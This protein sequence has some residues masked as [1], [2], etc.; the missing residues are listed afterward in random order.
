MQL[1]MLVAGCVLLGQAP[2]DAPLPFAV[3]QQ[4]AIA[5]TKP[6]AA[7]QVV[8][9]SNPAARSTDDDVQTDRAEL[10]EIGTDGPPAETPLPFVPPAQSGPTPPEMVAEALSPPS[11]SQLAGQPLT[12]LTALSSTT[13]HRHQLEVTHAYW[14]LAEA[15]AV[16]HFSLD[17]DR[18]LR[19][20]EAGVEQAPC[21]RTARASSL[22][23]V[24][25]A[26]V[27]AVA[28][29]HELAA[30]V[31]LSP[32]ASLPLPADRPHVG[33]YRTHFDRLFPI[34]TAPARTKLIDRT[35]PIRCR[36]ID[37]RALAVQAADDALSAVRDAHRLRRAELPEVLTCMEESLRQRQ[38]LIRSVCRYNHEIADY[39]L[40]VVRPGSSPQTLVGMLIK[41]TL[42]PLRPLA[43][44]HD[45]ALEPAVYLERT[46][47]PAQRPGQNVPTPARRPGQ[48]VPT[49]ARRPGQNEPTPAPPQTLPRT[50]EKEVPTPAARWL[51][52]VSPAKK[53]PA[54]APPQQEPKP[55][56]PVSS[57]QSL[58]PVVPNSS[59]STPSTVNKPVAEI[60]SGFCSPALYPALTDVPPDTQARQLTLTLY[61]NH[62]LPEQTSE[63]ISLADCL[64]QQ[65]GGDRRGLIEVYWF[66]G[67]RAAEYQVL[68]QQAGLLDSLVLVPSQNTE[69][70]SVLRLRSASSAT[71]AALHEAHAALLEAQFE[72]AT[73]LGRESDAL[74]PIPDTPPCSQRYAPELDAQPRRLAGSWPLRRLAAMIPGLAESVRLRAA[75]VVEADA[76][77]AAACAASSQ[78]DARSIEPLLAS[79]NRQ[80]RQTFAFLNT[81][82]DY[83]QVIAGHAL[84][85]FPP[86]TPADEL[87]A[88]LAPRPEQSDN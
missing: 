49:P 5:E 55:L 67:R 50:P 1:T 62:T 26:E 36:A 86:D 28:A 42:Q 3:P 58:V 88:A 84:S 39:A 6:A 32:D 16:Y 47:T 78:A 51:P 85:V 77:R 11:D 74:W 22:A 37:G 57:D 68:A 66:A 76:A 61:W 53:E 27:A 43:S 70:V 69:R 87:A 21:L 7:E 75:A 8:P 9:E 73:R 72:L 65:P 54:S 24:H 4:P 81:L 80:T 38:A 46:P 64:G 71:Q 14:G 15:V 56:P 30:L 2:G 17:H 35:L 33:A 83:N 18:Q 25:E 40:A 20:L 19:D 45:A 82:T 12:L 63:P 13:D 44:E 60:P 31:L 23:L 79:I 34:R 41:P 29:Q 10:R 52:S 59:G 48:N